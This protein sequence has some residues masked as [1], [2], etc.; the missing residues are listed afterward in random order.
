M[1]RVS[2]GPS[3]RSLICALREKKGKKGK[4]RR[5]RK[6]DATQDDRGQR[7]QISR[8]RRAEQ[9][10][11][12]SQRGT[13]IPFK[14][15]EVKKTKEGKRE[16]EGRGKI[17]QRIQQDRAARRSEMRTKQRLVVTAYRTIEGYNLVVTVN[18]TQRTYRYSIGVRTIANRQLV[19]YGGLSEHMQ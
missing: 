17:R 2:R 8:D 11:A 12:H 3:P 9:G 13:T 4:Q 19:N 15:N 14:F 7:N 5:N 18:C 10:S 16:R 6:W 1:R